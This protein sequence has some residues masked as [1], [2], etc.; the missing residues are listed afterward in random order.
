MPCFGA[1]NPTLPQR[2]VPGNQKWLGKHH[3]ERTKQ[4]L[5]ELKLGM[6]K[7]EQHIMN[8]MESVIG[9]FWYGNVRYLDL[10]YCPR[11][12]ADLRERCRAYWNYTCFECGT[13]QNGK[14]LDVHH[15][16]YNKKMLCDGSP[17]DV[18]PL[19][20]GCHVK[21]NTDREYW[22]RYFTELLYSWNPKGKCFF[23]EDE[24]KKYFA[25]N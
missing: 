23:T 4:I 3:S 12:T 9:G 20:R 22:E 13:P 1:P 18:I 15:I 8:R 21:T 19:C 5:R 24:M 25:P 11:W 7:T 2:A 17:Q 14:K 10:P 6:P 16:H